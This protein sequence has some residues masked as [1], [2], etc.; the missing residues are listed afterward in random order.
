LEREADRLADLVTRGSFASRQRDAATETRIRRASANVDSAPDPN[1]ATPTRIRRAA[2]VG[3]EGGS[4]DSAIEQSLESAPA[5]RF[6]DR[7][8]RR[9]AHR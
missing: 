9:A 1:P 6:E 7:A 3:A 2:V 4:L 8:Q 5:R